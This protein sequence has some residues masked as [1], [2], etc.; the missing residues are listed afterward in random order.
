MQEPDASPFLDRDVIASLLPAGCTVGR[1]MHV[2]AETD[3]TNDLARRAG[4]G[5]AAEGIV[6][7]AEAQRRGRG[8]EGRAWHSPLGLG[9]WLSVLLRPQAARERWHRLGALTALCVTRGVE[10]A[11]S[12][13]AGVKWPNDLL[14]P[15]GRKCGGILVETTPE[16]AVVGIGLN[17]FHAV[18]DFPPELRVSAGSLRMAQADV[19]RE[20]VAAAVLGALDTLHRD[21][22]AWS[23][24]FSPLAAELA[25][26]SA[27]L[28]R[29]VRVSRGGAPVEGFAESLDAEARLILRCDDGRRVTISA[30]ETEHCRATE[31]ES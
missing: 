13:R 28:G 26:R 8:R 11:S 22:A 6:F 29:R 23:D 27:T 4:E 19:G 12:V 5:G 10:A 16:F 25:A 14:L 31:V 7:F 1:E 15:N 21:Q 20:R 2:F 30:G 9:L 24:D 3:S 17:V 18:G